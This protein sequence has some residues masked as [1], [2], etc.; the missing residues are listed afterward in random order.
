MRHH[1]I[2]VPMP[3]YGYTVYQCDIRKCGKEEG[4]K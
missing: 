2:A 3:T 1:Q 4:D